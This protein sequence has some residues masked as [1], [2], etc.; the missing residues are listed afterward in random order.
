[1]NAKKAFQIITLTALMPAMAAAAQ[2]GKTC[3]GRLTTVAAGGKGITV[4]DSF[5]NRTFALSP[6]CVILTVHSKTASWRDLQLGEDV[7][8]RYER[9]NGA[10]V[11]KSVAEKVRE[12]AGSIQSIDLEGGIASVTDGSVLG[13]AR[14]SRIFRLAKPCEVTLPNGAG[15]SLAQVKPGDTVT[16]IYKVPNGMPVAYRIETTNP[17]PAEASLMSSNNR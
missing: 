17:R 16:I 4:T 2:Q 13:L 5:R 3:A 7:V 12:C 15:G 8:V 9:M 11:A 14:T 10:L 6:N 1:M